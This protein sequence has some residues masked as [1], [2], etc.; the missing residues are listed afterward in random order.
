MN[1][2]DS[3]FRME[4]LKKVGS[5]FKKG[6][7]AAFGREDRKVYASEQFTVLKERVGEGCRLS[8]YNVLLS[9]RK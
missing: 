6:E 4:R 1:Y 9:A 8:V 2:V 7:I 3:S 5:L